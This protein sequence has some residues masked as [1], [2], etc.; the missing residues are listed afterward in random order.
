MAHISTSNHLKTTYLTRSRHIFLALGIIMNIFHEISGSHHQ[1]FLRPHTKPAF[2]QKKT[3]FYRHINFDVNNQIRFRSIY[4]MNSMI[5]LVKSHHFDIKSNS[6]D[7]SS[8]QSYNNR[9]NKCIIISFLVE[10]F[11]TGSS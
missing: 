4:F 7:R 8:Q 6:F 5:N 11:V 3:F 9:G 10:L 1:N 2:L